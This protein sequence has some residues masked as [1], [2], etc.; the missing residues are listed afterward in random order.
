[1]VRGAEG[2]RD[3]LRQLRAGGGV[4]GV[5]TREGFEIPEPVEGLDDLLGVG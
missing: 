4:D 2:G 5:G 1:L 3:V